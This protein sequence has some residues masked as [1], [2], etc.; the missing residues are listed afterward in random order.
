VDN[1]KLDYFKN[2]LIELRTKQIN[3]IKSINQSYITNEDRYSSLELSNYD[4]HPGELGT[5]MQDNEM[6]KALIVNEKAVLKAIDE[7]LRKINSVTYGK[8]SICGRNI[9]EKRL[10]FIPYAVECVSCREKQKRKTVQ[11]KDRPV[12]E[13]IL[14]APFGRKYLNK[15]EDDESEGLDQ[16]NDLMKYGSASTPQDMGGYEE[17]RDYYNNKTDNQGVVDNMDNVSNKDYKKQLPGI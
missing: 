2:R 6:S 4:N 8:C 15:R 12:E 10:E 1:K 13:L 5:N 7:A 17:Y 9:D 3:F 11:G 16:L 14:D